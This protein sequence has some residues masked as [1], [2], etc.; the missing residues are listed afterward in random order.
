MQL[1]IA[2]ATWRIER[3]NESAFFCRITLVF[4]SI[5]VLVFSN[6]EQTKEYQRLNVTSH[7]KRT[8]SALNFFVCRFQVWIFDL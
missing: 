5:F 2:P 3:R 1:Q 7:Y 8:I 4:F 6:Q